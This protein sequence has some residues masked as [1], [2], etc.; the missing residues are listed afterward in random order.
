[1]EEKKN[2]AVMKAEKAADPRESAAERMEK[3]RDERRAAQER[4][5][6]DARIARAKAKLEQ[7]EEKKR[8]KAQARRAAEA[9]KAKKKAEALRVEREKEERRAAYYRERREERRRMAEQK[10]ERAKERQKRRD[11]RSRQGVG[12]WLAAVISLGVTVLVLSSVLAMNIL[13]PSTN[14][15]ALSAMYEKSYYDTLTYVNNMDNSL[16]KSLAT[17]DGGALQEYFTDLAVQSELA[18]NDINRLPLRDEAKYYTT[19]LI[20]QIGDFSK[21]L[22]KKLIDGETLSEADTEGLRQLYEANRQ[23]RESLA[24]ITANMGANYDFSKLEKDEDVL[25]G[26]EELQNLSAEY[27]ELIYDGPFSDGQPKDKIKG[28]TGEEITAEE[29]KARFVAIFNEYGIT[30]IEEQGETSGLFDCY[31]FTAKSEGTRL[32]AQISKIGGHLILF[33]CFSD[34][35]TVNYDGEDL[36]PVGKAFLESLGLE[37]MTCVWAS[38]SRAVTSLNFAYEENGIIVYSDLIKLTVCQETGKVTGMEAAP[39]YTNHVARQMPKAKLSAKE[40]VKQVSSSLTVTGTRLAYIPK[41]ENRECLAYEFRAEKD[42][43]IYY[44]YIDA[45][46]G[47]QTEMFRVIDTDDGVMLL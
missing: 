27:P 47:R 6:A 3:E 16:A 1:M 14:D 45:I 2:S 30:E 33:D 8:R 32:F 5:N 21:Y 9:K 37:N 42:G 43:E 29:A 34:C 36:I 17:K 39:Y 13:M 35:T 40:A 10:E 26:M 20:N 7:K 38:S 25:S 19:K 11:R 12:G 46:T 22:N 4:Q 41:S 18:E 15:K 31:N 23:L 28:L 24:E 44:V